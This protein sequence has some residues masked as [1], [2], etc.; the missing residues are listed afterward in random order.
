MTTTPAKQDKLLA[1]LTN[2]ISAVKETAKAQGSSVLHDQSAGTAELCYTVERIMNFG[3][4]DLGLL[5]RTMM[6]DYMK[7]IDICFPNGKEIVKIISRH[8]KTDAGRGRTLIRHGLNENCLDEYISCLVW[9]QKLTSTFYTQSSILRHE[10]LSTTFLDL[11]LELKDLSFSLPLSRELDSVE[12]W[13]ERI[14]RQQQLREQQEQQEKQRSQAAVQSPSPAEKVATRQAVPTASA[15]ATGVKQQSSEPTQQDNQAVKAIKQENVQL[16]V[17][18]EKLQLE[19]QSLQSALASSNQ[20]IE[21]L[22]REV[23]MHRERAEQLVAEQALSGMPQITEE[24]REEIK[25]QVA[26][27]LEQK[28]AEGADQWSSSIDGLSSTLS[29]LQE[30]LQTLKNSEAAFHETHL[31][32]NTDEPEEG[33]SSD[34][35][36]EMPQS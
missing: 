12:Y 8:S 26:E 6:W 13:S 23:S 34:Q 21:D 20:Q 9:N 29:K 11:L 5:S 15:V 16:K 31:A 30:D 33:L 36:I 7:K 32:T 27:A 4:R 18:L 35:T 25:R 17:Q 2:R 24:E 22:K 1:E 14:R 3:L 28:Q 10:S 19:K